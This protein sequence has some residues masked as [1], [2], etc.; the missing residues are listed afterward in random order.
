MENNLFKSNIVNLYGSSGEEWLQR[1][2]KFVSEIAATYGLSDLIPISNLSYHYVMSGFQDK[3]SII[4]KLGLD[5]DEL[6]QEVVALKAFAGFGAVKIIIQEDGLLLLE[7][8]MPGNSLKSYFPSNDNEAIRIAASVMRKLHLAPIAQENHFPHLKDWLSDLDQDWNIPA[9]YL[10]KAR[11]LRDDLLVTAATSVLLHGDLHH[12]NI[13]QNGDDWVVIDPK[14]VIGEPA[15]EVAAF[16]RNP[17]PE[18]LS[19]D[20]LRIISNRITL[21]STALTL[22]RQRILDWC[23]VQAVLA[24]TWSLEDGGDEAYFKQLTEVFYEKN[25]HA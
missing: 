19:L 18:L 11:Q 9:N 24:W 5:A 1:L 14:G 7:R 17:I 4:L 25:N 20:A 16:I 8:A 2:P 13:L 21:F 15:Y 23:F 10:Q 12:D 6:R 22:P 3:Q